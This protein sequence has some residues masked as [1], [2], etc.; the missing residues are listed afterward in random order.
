MNSMKTGVAIAVA[1]VILTCAGAARAAAK[2]AIRIA[3]IDEEK[4]FSGYTKTDEV[5]KQ[6]DKERTAQE[7]GLVKLQAELQKM[8]TE[9]DKQKDLLKPEEKTKKE[10]AIRT[11]TQGYLESAEKI[12]QNLQTTKAQMIMT[13]RKE[14]KDAVKAIAVKDKYDY[15]LEF[16][17]VHYGPEGDD[18]TQK[19]IDHLNK[20]VKK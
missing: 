15:V 6:F 1:A 18:L 12:S 10:D 13:I 16:Q 8:R 11:K 20:A 9:L 7:E 5:Q 2:D 3:Y 4:V 14:I 19:V 17:V